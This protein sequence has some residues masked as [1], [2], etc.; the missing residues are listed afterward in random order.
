MITFNHAIKIPQTVGL[1]R[2]ISKKYFTGVV[3][4][5]IEELRKYSSRMFSWFQ[6]S[7]CGNADFL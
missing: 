7:I 6:R 5:P 2:E 4:Y 1:P 3:N